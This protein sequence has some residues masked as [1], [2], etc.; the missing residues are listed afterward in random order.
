MACLHDDQDSS[1][2][3]CQPGHWQPHSSSLLATVRELLAV[4]LREQ[5]PSAAGPFGCGRLLERFS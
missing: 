1:V 2:T 5:G 3:T 4:G